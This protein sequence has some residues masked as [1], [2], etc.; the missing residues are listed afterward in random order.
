MY[1]VVI[2]G[3]RCAGSPLAMLLA[4]QGHKVLIVDRATFPSDTL[5]TH[6]VQSP[7][8][9][10]LSQWGLL[11]PLLATGCSPITKAIFEVAG[12]EMNFD[13]PMPP[14]LPGLL[15]PR[16][17]VLD[18][19]LVDAAVDAGAELAEGVTVE[20]L[21]EEEGRIVGISGRTQDGQFEARGRFVVGADGRHS[22]VADKVDA[23]MTRHV[24]PLTSGYYSYFTNTGITDTT[25][26][27]FSDDVMSV[28][29]PTHDD[30]VCV[31][32]IWAK[33]RQKEMKRDIEGNFNRGLETFG[34]FGEAI[35][36]G[37]RVERFAGVH[38]L[39]NF[40]RNFYG[41]GWAL[42][43]DAGYHKDPVPADGIS[44]AFRGAEMLSAALHESLAD[45]DEAKAMEAYAA[46]YEEVA[47]AHFD[48]AVRSA[49]F[50]LGP[51]QRGDAFFESRGLDF[52][53]VTALTS[54]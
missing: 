2:V 48:P 35:L 41:P 34:K 45:G 21:I 33:E 26:G 29:F 22:V 47:N 31:A 44:D 50:E 42:V 15:C 24:G 6:F 11:E 4:R 3:A 46:G 13:I 14:S 54:T 8:V 19:L 32:I 23:P 16:R 25:F 38:D 28:Q 52:A 53:E 5:S 39:D 36:G 20:S 17:H 40:S 51:K 27:L 10:R 30:A 1:D 7:G 18:K 9:Y 12:V 37:E 43:G 49:N